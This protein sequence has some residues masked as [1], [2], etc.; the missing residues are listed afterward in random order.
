VSV[1]KPKC[2]NFTPGEQSDSCDAICPYC[3]ATYQ[4]ESEDYSEFDREEEC[5]ECEKT[6]IIYQ[7]FEVTTHTKPKEEK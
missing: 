5:F 7:S 3:G 6:Y 2:A 1:S 4:V